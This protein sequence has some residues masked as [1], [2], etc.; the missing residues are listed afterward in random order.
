MRVIFAALVS[1]QDKNT[2]LHVAA[3]NGHAGVAKALLA[4]G[5]NV[6]ATEKVDGEG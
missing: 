5:A 6:H 4:A 2:P 3:F 1:T